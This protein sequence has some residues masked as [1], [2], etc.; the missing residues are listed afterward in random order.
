MDVILFSNSDTA[1]IAINEKKKKSFWQVDESLEEV[2]SDLSPNLASRVLSANEVFQIG[3]IRYRAI[4]A[5]ILFQNPRLFI[6]RL[7]SLVKSS[8][9]LKKI[10]SKSSFIISIEGI[11]IKKT[12]VIL[13]SSYLDS[14]TLFDSYS[15]FN[16][17]KE[18]YKNVK[19]NNIHLVDPAQALFNGIISEVSEIKKPSLFISACDKVEFSL[20]EKNGDQIRINLGSITIPELN[21]YTIN[22][23]LTKPGLDYVLSRSSANISDDYTKIYRVIL[24]NLYEHM[25]KSGIKVKSVFI[26]TPNEFLIDKEKLR[27]DNSQKIYFPSDGTIYP[28]KLKKEHRDYE[29]FFVPILKALNLLPLDEGKNLIPLKG[30]VRSVRKVGVISEFCKVELWNDKEK[31]ESFKTK[32]QFLEHF[33]MWRL[34]KG[35]PN[36]YKF[37][38]KNGIVNTFQVGELKYEAE[39]DSY[40]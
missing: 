31:L 39:L 24:S 38:Y 35:S 4:S 12:G 11:I 20:L 17:K 23:L 29:E 25:I 13:E 22:F 14:F 40:L 36:S 26:Y 6:P 19:Q 37:I 18:L 32:S 34:T 28:V 9:S 16:I 33:K 1:I 3:N 10:P 15:G 7:I 2:L 27:K 30:C 21:D 5:K 8:F